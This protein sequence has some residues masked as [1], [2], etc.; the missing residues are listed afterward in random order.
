[1]SSSRGFTLIELLIVV[2]IIG[3][4]SATV[5]VSLNTARNKGSDAAI[6]KE[7]SSARRLAELYNDNNGRSYENVCSDTAVTN[8]VT[9]INP[10]LLKIAQQYNYT[11]N[12]ENLTGNATRVT[13]NDSATEWAAEAPLRGGGF[14]CVDWRGEATTTPNSRVTGCSG[15]CDTKC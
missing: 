12:I 3:I 5:L 10:I 8:G 7:L 4:L 11:V 1:M 6:K 2:A 14:F 9:S 13:C 15:V